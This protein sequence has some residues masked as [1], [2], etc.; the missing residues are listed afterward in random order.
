MSIGFDEND[1]DGRGQQFLE[2]VFYIKV[3]SSF[4]RDSMMILMNV[5]PPHINLLDLETKWVLIADKMWVERDPIKPDFFFI[6][7]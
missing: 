2:N 4:L 7:D 5:I 6:L 3:P 1:D